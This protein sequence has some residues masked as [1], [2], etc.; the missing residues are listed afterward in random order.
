MLTAF[1]FWALCILVP[2]NSEAGTKWEKSQY[3]SLRLIQA[4]RLIQGGKTAGDHKGAVLTGIH[5]K[6]APEWKTYW[7]MPGDAG[8]PPSF[9]WSASKNIKSA[10]IL[11]PAPHRLPDPYGDSIGYKKEVIFPVLITPQ[12]PGEPVTLRLKMEYG[13]C[14]DIC[15]PV[16]SDIS[17]KVMTADTSTGNERMLLEN[18]LRQVPVRHKQ[19]S[20]LEPAIRAV[21][22]NLKGKK[23]HLLIKASFPDGTTQRDLFI[24]TSSDIYLPMAQRQGKDSGNMTTFRVDLSQTDDREKLLGKTIICTLVSSAGQSE[25]QWHIK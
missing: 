25:T 11:Y 13:I 18:Y 6:L 19:G 1:I 5:I 4:G 14:K 16:S 10:K 3:G 20:A 8:I 24:E 23:P 17:M 15:I 21:S 7:R 12:N 22:I 2:G 9:D